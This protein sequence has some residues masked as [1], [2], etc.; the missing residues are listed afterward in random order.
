[1]TMTTFLAA[2]LAAKHKQNNMEE[3][4]LS[5]IKCALIDSYRLETN[6][7]FKDER[8]LLNGICKTELDLVDITTHKE[9]QNEK[10]KS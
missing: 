2:L 8:Q 3:I 10:N 6:E 1:M 7:W 9:K 5:D 4:L